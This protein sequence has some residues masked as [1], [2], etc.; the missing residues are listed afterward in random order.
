MRIAFVWKG[1]SWKTTLSSLFCSYASGT[2]MPVI[3]FDA[4]I[5]RHLAGQF[6]ERDPVSLS[7][8]SISE[9]IRNWLRWENTRIENIASFRKTTPPWWGSNIIEWPNVP[10]ILQSYHLRIPPHLTLF[11]VGTYEKEDIWKSC[12]HN[13]LALLENILSH[14][15]ERNSVTVVDMVAGTDAFASTLHAQFDMFVCIILPTR[16]SISVWNEFCSLAESAFIWDRVYALGNWVKSD[17]DE[18]Y[19][20]DHIWSKKYLWSF[21]FDPHITAFDH[22]K[23][24]RVESSLLKENNIHLLDKLLSKLKESE[25]DPMIRLRHLHELHKKY[26]SQNFIQKQFWDLTWQIDRNFQ[27]SQH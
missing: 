4:D 20:I 11:T 25:I 15:I 21:S 26:I 24:L 6:W 7:S 8:P 3:W 14:S 16:H 10:D 19:I 2:G 5:N 1:G 12:Y 9:T 17:D 27:Y 23:V 13:N 18:K 22:W